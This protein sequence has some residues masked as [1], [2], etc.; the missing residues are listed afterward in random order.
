MDERKIIVLER[1]WTAEQSKNCFLEM[2]LISKLLSA[3]RLVASQE[4]VRCGEVFMD[5]EHMK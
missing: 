4:I 1:Q 2:D 3:A 5:G